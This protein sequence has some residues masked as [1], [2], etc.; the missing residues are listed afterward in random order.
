MSH[1]SAVRRRIGVLSHSC[2]EDTTLPASLPDLT[3][4]PVEAHRDKVC[5]V[6][7]QSAR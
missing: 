2:T 4:G 5:A 6:E 1:G 7:E 3:R